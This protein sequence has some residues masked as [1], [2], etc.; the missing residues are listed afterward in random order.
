MWV[1]S[2]IKQT[3]TERG[4]RFEKYYC[5]KQCLIPS[6]FEGIYDDEVVPYNKRDFLSGV[7][8]GNYLYSYNFTEANMHELLKQK[9][10]L[11]RELLKEVQNNPGNTYAKLKSNSDGEIITFKPSKDWE[12]DESRTYSPIV[13]EFDLATRIPRIY[14]HDTSIDSDLFASESNNSIRVPRTHPN[15]SSSA[16]IM[17][18]MSINEEIDSKRSMVRVQN[19]TFTYKASMLSDTED[20]TMFMKTPFSK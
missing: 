6:F 11:M 17:S 14:N 5:K 12:E 18:Q 2:Y 7:L 8:L 15:N 3:L 13:D 1:N 19:N 4:L 16:S 10:Y 20:R 9:K